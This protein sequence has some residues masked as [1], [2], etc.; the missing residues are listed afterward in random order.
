MVTK[1]KV[2]GSPASDHGPIAPSLVFNAM[3]LKVLKDA[4]QHI[5]SIVGSKIGPR[6]ANDSL[7]YI[8]EHVYVSIVS[9]TP[10]LLAASLGVS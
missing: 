5:L 3:V 1:P 6:G 2:A 8:P 9:L 4:F 10:K 7:S